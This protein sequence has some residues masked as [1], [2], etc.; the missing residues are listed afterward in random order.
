LKSIRVTFN[1]D[2]ALGKERGIPPPPPPKK[3][4]DDRDILDGPSIHESKTNSFHDPMEPMDPLD[5]PP[6]GPPTKKIPL[7]LRDTL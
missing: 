7:W 1:E 5:P 4:N 6:S 3:R 2:A